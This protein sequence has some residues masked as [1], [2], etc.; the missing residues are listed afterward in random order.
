MDDMERARLSYEIAKEN[1]GKKVILMGGGSP[2][3]EFNVVEVVDVVDTGKDDK[4]RYRVKVK[5]KRYPQGKVEEFDPWMYSWYILPY[6]EN[7]DDLPLGTYIFLDD[8]IVEMPANIFATI[9]DAKVVAVR[10][11]KRFVCVNS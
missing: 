9:Y 8:R 5:W 10:K 6:P 11:G 3:N 1:I 2:A 7:L 4:L